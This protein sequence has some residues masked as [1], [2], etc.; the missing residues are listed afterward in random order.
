MIV[1][2]PIFGFHSDGWGSAMNIP[3]RSEKNYH[4]GASSRNMIVFQNE[5]SSTLGSKDMRL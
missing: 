4:Q 2:A 5:Y 3:I 1:Y